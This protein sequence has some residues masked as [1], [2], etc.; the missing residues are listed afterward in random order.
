MGKR[1]LSSNLLMNLSKPN[2][3]L[4]IVITSYREPNATIRAIQSFID[5]RIKVNHKI[6][7]SDPFHETEKLINAH[8]KGNKNIEF[9]LDPGEGKGYALNLILEKI[10][11]TNTDEIIILTDGDV[12]VGKDSVKEILNAFKDKQVGC[13]TGKLVSLNSRK[14]KMGYW[15]HLLF[16]GADMERK[17]LSKKEKFFECSGYLF[18]IRNGVLQGFPMETSEDSVI[19]Y[20]FWKKGYKIKYI[21][22]AEV[23][24]LNPNNKKEWVIQKVRNIKA[25]ENLKKVAGDMPRTKTF[26]NEV[27]EGGF[28][29]L[30][31]SKNIREFVWTWDLFMIRLYIWIKAFYELKIKKRGYNDGWRVE[32]IKST[33]PLD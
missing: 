12:Y 24:I 30:G 11:S 14:E 19:P 3:M 13:I 29:S 27:K 28:F 18:A 6:I 20:L 32:D 2:K 25:H 1:K 8:F 7:V 16:A 4:Y 21:P 33:K 17:K 5:Q 15:S 22:E 10:Y 9:F 23:Y 31:Y 26:F